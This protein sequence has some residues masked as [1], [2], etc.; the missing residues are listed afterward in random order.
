MNAIMKEIEAL[1]K[2]V[3]NIVAHNNEL[4]VLK[5]ENFNVFEIFN[6]ESEENKVHFSLY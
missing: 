4:L 1:L 3:E 2:K 6:M 5:G